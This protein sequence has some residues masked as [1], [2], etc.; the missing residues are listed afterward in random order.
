MRILAV[1]AALTAAMVAFGLQ[2]ATNGWRAET[3]RRVAALDAGVPAQ[4]AVFAADALKDLP[5]PVARYFTHVLREGQPL[6]RTARATQDAEFFIGND[7]HPLTA[8]QYFATRP[9][10]F[11][12]DAR[13]TMA[14]LMTVYVR[15]S[16]VAGR[17]S[18]LAS[19]LAGYS[20]VDQN[21]KPELNAG[22]LQRFLGES[23][24]LPTALLPGSDVAWGAIDDHRAIATISDHGSIVA[25]TFT[26]N[27]NDEAIELLGDRFAEKDG[28]YTLR[29]WRVACR[30]YEDRAGMLIPIACE[31]SWV[32]PEGP[33]PYWRG[34][35]TSIDY[36]F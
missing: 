2:R 18:M 31:V 8:T 24:W 12:W 29:P 14:P 9:A 35:L 21:D 11:V 10:G 15:D 28:A 34:R 19:M 20:L 27:D 25:L 33:Q 17:G 7:W 6:I 23:V 1:A 32:M 30:Q 13:I 4:P 26:F 22:A 3:D 5:P 16:Y 36:G